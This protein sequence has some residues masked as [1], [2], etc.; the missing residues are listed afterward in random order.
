ML[1]YVQLFGTLWTVACLAS[2]SMELSRQEYWSGLPFT[3]SGDLP[4]PGIRPRSPALQAESLQL[5]PPGNPVGKTIAFTIW[6][7][8]YKV[9]SLLFNTVSRLVITFLPRNKHLL[10]SLQYYS[11]LFWSPRKE[12]V[13]AHIFSPSICY[14][15]RGL[16]TM[17]LVFWMLSFKPVFLLSS[18]TIIKR[19]FSSSSVLAIKVAHLRLLIFLLGNLDSSLWFIQPGIS[20]DILCI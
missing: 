11:H 9:M 3:S 13:T 1:N 15:V 2:L 8:V 16:D 4:E 17:I 7:F 5:E 19:L 6:T 10:I 14:E 20:H 12:Y 18:F